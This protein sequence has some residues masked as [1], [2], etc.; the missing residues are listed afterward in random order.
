MVS[1]AGHMGGLES[2]SS[3]NKQLFWRARQ[4][5]RK[6]VYLW[7][8]LAGTGPSSGKDPVPYLHWPGEVPLPP[9]SRASGVLLMI[10]ITLK[11]DGAQKP[12]S[13]CWRRLCFWS[14]ECWVD[15]EKMDQSNEKVRERHPGWSFGS[16]GA[17]SWLRNR[18]HVDAWST[19]NDDV[20]IQ[21]CL[22]LCDTT[23]L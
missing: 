3:V 7:G 19:D 4:S 23:V 9:N 16:P 11:G 14:L 22:T 13:L 17:F 2:C 21:L 5:D 10:I 20:C 1:P 8:F 15:V 12:N 6:G 18:V